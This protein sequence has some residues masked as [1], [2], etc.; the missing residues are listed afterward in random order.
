MKNYLVILSLFLLLIPNRSF[1]Q[2]VNWVL[3]DTM[4]NSFGPASFS[5]NPIAYYPESNIAALV[6]KGFYTYATSESKLWYN[7]STDHGQTWTR[8]SAVDNSLS[9]NVWYPSMTIGGTG[10]AKGFFCWGSDG[11]KLGYALT[12]SLIG[13]NIISSIDSNSFNSSTCW[14]N[15]N[16]WFFWT[17]ANSDG[18]IFLFRT[19]NLINIESIEIPI[20]LD[21]W[22]TL[23]GCSLNDNIYLGYI[24]TFADPD[25]NNPICSGWYPGYIKSTDNGTTWQDVKVVDFRTINGLESY[26]RLFD[27]IK[28]SGSFVSYAGDI[29]VD[30]DGYVHLIIS[31]TD[32]TTHNNTGINSLIEI[33]ESETG[34][35]SKVIYEGISDSIFTNKIGPGIEQMGPSGY[36]AFDP[37]REVMACTWVM[38]NKNSQLGLCDIFIS[39]RTLNSEWS[40]PVNLTET[41]EMNENGAHM[42]PSLGK[43]VGGSYTAFV[44]YFYELDYYGQ[45]PNE[46]NPAGFWIA[47][48][49]FSLTNVDVDKNIITHFILEQNYPN[50]FNPTT[51]IKYTLAETSNITLKVYDVLGKEVATLINEERPAGVYEVEFDA[52]SLSSGIYFYQLQTETFSSVKKMILLK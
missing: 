33:Y 44:G 52:S 13:G 31:V 9:F 43:L 26:D 3:V 42:A 20:N 19:Q 1:S 16:N 24:G 45:E 17:A 39:Y 6:H 37:N 50:P 35:K 25:S 7:T 4:S 32:T 36:L 29:N 40:S 46:N 21:E 15:D 48:F 27:F 12:N 22:L 18:N 51:S 23:G 10:D 47:P 49:N 28:D 2:N 11:L 5:V 41:N 34:W 14:S 30:K 8:I 38:D